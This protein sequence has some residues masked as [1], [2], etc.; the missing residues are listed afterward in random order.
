MKKFKLSKTLMINFSLGLI[1]SS[2]GFLMVAT[3]D[4]KSPKVKYLSHKI[5][6]VTQEQVEVDLRLK[7]HNPNT[8]GLKNVFVSYELFTE[9]NKISKGED[10]PL[11]LDPEKETVI[12][13]PVKIM[14]KGVLSSVKPILKKLIKQKKTLPVEIRAVVYG[15]PTVYNNM[16]EGDLFSFS[17]KEKK[18][19]QVPLPQTKDKVQKKVDQMKNKAK[20]ALKKLF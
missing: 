13:V 14:Y 7:A 20:D 12:K 18:I 6:K 4:I 9:G 16:A 19:I 15:K 17:H 10:I 8:I 1:L 3:T 2:C 11:K 5:E